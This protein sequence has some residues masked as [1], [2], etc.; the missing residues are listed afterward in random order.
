MNL[1]GKYDHYALIS[2]GATYVS[3]NAADN[4]TT[5]RPDIDVSGYQAALDALTAKKNAD[6]AKQAALERISRIRAELADH[7]ATVTV[8]T[9]A[10]QGVARAAIGSLRA[11]LALNKAKL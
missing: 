3:Y 6:Q 9:P 10:E 11:E 2:L 7:L 5:V 1:N 4:T 8:G